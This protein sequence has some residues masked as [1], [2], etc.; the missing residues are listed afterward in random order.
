MIRTVRVGDALHRVRRPIEVDPTTVYEEVGIRSFGKGFFPKPPIFG[1]ELGNKR[2]FEINKGDLV[3]NIVFAWEG[4]VALAGP[5]EHKKCAS[6]RFPTY[7]ADPE[8]CDPR[9]LRDFFTTPRGRAALGQASPG[10]AGRNRTLNLR[11]FE[12]IQIE[13]PEVREQRRVADQIA[14]TI[15]RIQA[16]RTLRLTA[17]NAGTKLIGSILVQFDRSAL[18]VP[19]GEV[20]SL[21]RDE[22][23]V[24]VEKTYHTAGI[25][26][27]GRGLFARPPITGA[28]TKYR[29][30]YRL[31][32]DQLVLSQLNGWEGAIAIV[33][34]HFDGTLVSQEYPTFNTDP[35]QADP[36]YL[37]WLCQWPHFWDSLV[38]RGSMVRRK[39]VHPDRLLVT[40]VP[41]PTL[42]EQRRLA[43]L[44]EM[45][46]RLDALTRDFDVAFRALE[47]SII[48]AAI[49]GRL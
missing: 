14:A 47:P 9:Y 22:V 2:M 27:F 16:A 38:P 19:L 1:I 23:P 48:G 46:D 5:K 34:P 36:R 25:Y 10:S 28:D 41:L 37:N 4:A 12:A 3:L 21:A 26:S 29:T 43:H 39:R 13:L 20:L 33:P 42:E 31:H 8:L 7:V 15:E 49:G 32:K 24:E 18:K 11:A 30:L 40:Q 44:A 35:E 45:M 6:H 17:G